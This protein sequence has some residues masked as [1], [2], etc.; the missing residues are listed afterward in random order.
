[1]ATLGDQSGLKLFRRYARNLS[2]HFPQVSGVFLC[3]I[4]IEPFS[5][6]DVRSESLRVDFGHI[7]PEEAGGNLTTLECCRCNG[8]LNRAGDNELVKLHKQWDAMTGRDKA[9]PI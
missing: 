1:M 7:Y 3:P 5:E 2:I 6:T 8:R 4:C 9:A